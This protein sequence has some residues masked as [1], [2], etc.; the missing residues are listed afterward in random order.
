M[1][2]DYLGCGDS[3]CLIERP[4]GMATNGGCRCL[5]GI[6]S[7]ERRVKIRQ[8]IHVLRT[9]IAYLKQQMELTAQEF[10][11]LK[12]LKEEFKI[13]GNTYAQ[14]IREWIKSNIK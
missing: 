1:V 11:D 13:P 4:K 3:G 7:P 12:S 8:A 5:E 10:E 2:K 14:S 6:T 9:E